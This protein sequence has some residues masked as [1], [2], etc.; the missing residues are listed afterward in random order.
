MAFQVL[1][2]RKTFP[3]YNHYGLK[4]PK[5]RAADAHSNRPGGEEA[6]FGPTNAVTPSW[7]RVSAIEQLPD[8][9]HRC[10]PGNRSLAKWTTRSDSE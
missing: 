1:T 4:D 2:W 9:K 6:V 8:P 10:A 5:A 7:R 3:D